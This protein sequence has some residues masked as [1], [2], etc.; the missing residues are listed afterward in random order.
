MAWRAVP[1]PTPDTTERAADRAGRLAALL[2]DPALTVGRLQEADAEVRV[3][4]VIAGYPPPDHRR[5]PVTLRGH[6]PPRYA[7]ARPRIG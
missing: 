6:R 1:G 3:P 7:G 5:T 4:P 2:T